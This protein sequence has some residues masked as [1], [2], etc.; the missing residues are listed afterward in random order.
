MSATIIPAG[1]GCKVEAPLVNW[2]ELTYHFSFAICLIILLLD[3]DVAR[4]AP[5]CYQSAFRAPQFRSEFA[6]AV[7][8]TFDSHTFIRTFCMVNL[9]GEITLV[10]KSEPET[11][12][13]AN[14]WQKFARQVD[15]PV[16]VLTGGYLSKGF[17][18]YAFQVN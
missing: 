8:L 15:V 14:G 2:Y 13:V 17:S 9:Q 11:M 18:K 6:S 3:M 1:N 4:P 5:K 16:G 7:P 10:K 12:L